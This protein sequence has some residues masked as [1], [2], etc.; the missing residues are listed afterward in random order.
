MFVVLGFT[1]ADV[2]KMF[3]AEYRQCCVEMLKIAKV[4]LPFKRFMHHSASYVRSRLLF[5][6]LQ[7]QSDIEQRF[8]DALSTAEKK[9]EPPTSFKGPGS[10]TVR[11]L[12]LLQRWP[13]E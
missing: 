6:L 12:S 1:K 10:P 5:E 13:S 3:T 7:Y 11:Q 8:L 2:S 4:G 9:Q